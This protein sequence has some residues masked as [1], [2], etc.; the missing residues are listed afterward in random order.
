MLLFF[1]LYLFIYVC[2]II[3]VCVN[4]RYANIFV[5]RTVQNVVFALFSEGLLMIC[6]RLHNPFSD[7]VLAFPEVL[8]SSSV[9]LN[10][11]L[12]CCTLLCSLLYR[13]LLCYISYPL[14]YY[15]FICFIQYVVA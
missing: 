9:L 8:H 5:S 15:V 13:I 7:D 3:C 2:V 11:L 12:L 4:I 1:S 10:V 6:D 14:L